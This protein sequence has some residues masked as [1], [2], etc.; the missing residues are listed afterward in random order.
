MR[1][2]SSEDIDQLYRLIPILFKLKLVNK[3]TRS[4][5]HGILFSQ[6]REIVDM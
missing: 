1:P 3:A 5:M 6:W 2:I 4:S